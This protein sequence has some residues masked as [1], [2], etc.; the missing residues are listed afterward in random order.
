M[1]LI[2]AYF[3]NSL[4]IFGLCKPGMELGT[5]PA[6]S[7]CYKP[8]G[9]DGKPCN[10]QTDCGTVSC[11]LVDRYSLKGKCE[12]IVFGCHQLIDKDGNLESLV[13]ID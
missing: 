11:V 3:S 8:S 9:Y 1:L 7:F 13:C 12:D 5:M 6:G 4:K 10:R 2:V